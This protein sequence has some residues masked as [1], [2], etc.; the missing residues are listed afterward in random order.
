MTEDLRQRR[1]SG[2]H[3]ISGDGIHLI[4]GIPFGRRRGPRDRPALVLPPRKRARITYDSEEEE[5]EEAG[6]PGRLLLEDTPRPDED[7]ES[8][9]DDDFA[10]NELSESDEDADEMEDLEADLQF[11]QPQR[12]TVQSSSGGEKVN[13]KSEREP[14]RERDHND[15]ASKS[16]LLKLE[17]MT[18]AA[19][20]ALRAAFPL[21]PSPALEAALD[22]HESNLEATYRDLASANDPDL[23]Y[24][25]MMSIFMETRFNHV[26]PPEPVLLTEAPRAAKPL[27]QEIED[28]DTQG[29]HSEEGGLTDTL[30]ASHPS[31]AAAEWNGLVDSTSSTGS[32][33]ASSSES[34]EE[35]DSD[36]NS[37]SDESDDS[38]F[39]EREASF[40]HNS[41]NSGSDSSEDSSDDSTQWDNDGDVR[42]QATKASKCLIQDVTNDA[43]S[44][45]SSSSED[46]DSDSSSESSDSEDGSHHSSD[47]TD[48]PSRRGLIL[49]GSKKGASVDTSSSSSDDSD[50]IS[51]DGSNHA[52]ASASNARQPAPI[53][54]ATTVPTASLPKVPNHSGPEQPQVGRGQGLSRTQKRNARRRQAKQ[55]RREQG[56]TEQP[57]DKGSTNPGSADTSESP[58]SN[59]K[60]GIADSASAANHGVEIDDIALSQKRAELSNAIEAAQTASSDDSSSSSAESSSDSSSDSGSGSGPDEEPTTRVQQSR[61]KIEVLEPT[62]AADSRVATATSSGDNLGKTLDDAGLLVTTATTAESKDES[63]RKRMRVDMG[64]GRRMLFGALGLKNPKSKADEEK[65]K[66]DLMKDVRPHQNHRKEAEHLVQEPSSE[67]QPQDEELDDWRDKITYR[68]VEC[69]YEGM[70]LS[71]PPF[72]FVQRWDPQQQYSSMR[73]RKRDS[74]HYEEYYEEDSWYEA[75][76]ETSSK[77][78]KNKNK[79]ASM[80]GDGQQEQWG[81]NDNA[82]IELNYDDTPTKPEAHGTEATDPDDDLPSLPADPNVLPAIRLEDVT[83]G[84]VIAWQRLQLSKA[85]NW[86]PQVE[87][88]TGMVVSKNQD[89]VHLML[90]K[91]DREKDEREFD[92]DG[93]RLYDKFEMPDEDGLGEEFKPDDGHRDMAWSELTDA[94]VVQ[95]APS[96]SMLGTPNGITLQGPNVESS[97]GPSGA[98]KEPPVSSMDDVD[99]VQVR[100]DVEEELMDMDNERD[101]PQG[102]YSIPS[103]QHDSLMDHPLSVEPT[104]SNASEKASQPSTSGEASGGDSQLHRKDHEIV[105]KDSQGLD[106]QPTINGQHHH[107]SLGERVS[108]TDDDNGVLADEDNEAVAGRQGH[109]ELGSPGKSSDSF[110]A[111]DDIWHTAKTS[112]TQKTPLK[113]SQGSALAQKGK[114]LKCEDGV[115]SQH[116]DNEATPVKDSSTRA[117]FPNATQPEAQLPGMAASSQS[118]RR[119]SRRR[120]QR[121]STSFVIPEGSQVVALSSSPAPKAAAEKYAED[122]RDDTYEDPESSSL[123]NGPGWV[124]KKTPGRGR[125]RKASGR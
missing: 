92:E 86:Q 67:A 80:Q 21:T 107:D 36:F 1:I 5:D 46:A 95:E 123:P 38:E 90:A 14:R 6:G 124:T 104:Y 66:K 112:R 60:G 9:G 96:P 29:H 26:S 100:A 97:A 41:Q 59:V 114:K 81:D 40:G 105:I 110:P 89:K 3:Q 17:G 23:D 85:T 18:P 109:K 102:S 7:D 108:A 52:H 47:D 77:K 71:E 125:P 54:P 119:S 16:Q 76:P 62:E 61:P 70:E 31:S 44:A 22:K 48:L 11:L 122:R 33:R 83:V 74:Q 56:T 19:L 87:W 35:S 93:N 42:V 116:S 57:T 10:E 64:A 2:R 20:V 34:D 91:R 117:L 118:P 98:A 79:R 37:D 24:N 58:G 73:K 13:S 106:G 65:L 78:K 45:Q 50:D 101:P 120:S 55:N 27:I 39:D 12:D 82:D 8:D 43:S 113:S 4:D 25:G 30:N 15:G 53:A 72:P 69:C 49:V 94:R 111:L 51:S 103:G 68:A 115:P 121:T 84:V 32:D 75:P 99:S 63:A 88:V 28:D